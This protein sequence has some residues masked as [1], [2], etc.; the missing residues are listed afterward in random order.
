MIDKILFDLF[1]I[2]L[3]LIGM[4]CALLPLYIHIND[5]INEKFKDEE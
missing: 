3:V 4:A 1:L 2:V 5:R